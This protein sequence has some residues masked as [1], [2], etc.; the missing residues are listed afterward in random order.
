MLRAVLIPLILA[1]FG[2]AA[3]AQTAA[4]GSGPDISPELGAL[5]DAVG[6]DENFE[7]LAEI[8]L[9]D[10]V[11]LEDSMFPGRGGAAWR[12]ILTGF[13]QPEPLQARFTQAFPADRMSREEMTAVTAFYRTDLGQRIVAGELSAWRAIS[14]A[15]S[16][17]AANAAYFQLLEENSPRLALLSEFIEVNGFVDLNVSGALNSNFAFYR[18]L[19]D[20]GAYEQALPPAMMLN[21]V[22]AQEPEIR[23]ETVLWLYSFQ[24]M[25]YQ[26]LSDA[27][28]ETYV[29]FSQTPAAQ[30]YNA[31]LFIG[32]DM[33]FETMSYQLGS[34]AALFMSGE[35]L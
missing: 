23:R 22:W 16:E 17:E 21:E 1:V 31:A 19:S 29:A 6:M 32:F 26:G 18:G 28:I 11:E 10:A 33:V 34:A 2:P 7:I 13:Y 15:A 8:G 35:R 20:A 3:L 14:D 9:A 27:E 4:P 25:A 30:A 5:F 24:L 12:A